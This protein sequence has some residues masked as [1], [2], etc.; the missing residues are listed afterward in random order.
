MNNSALQWGYLDLATAHVADACM[1]LGVPVRCAPKHLRPLWDGIHLVGRVHPVIHRGSVDVFL[2]ALD[3]SERGEVLVV[4]NGGR[5]D[6]A[7]IGD[8]VALE[9]AQAGL[10]GIV[11]WGL[12]RDTRQLTTIRMPIFSAGALAVGPDRAD[13]GGPDMAVSEASCGSHVVTAADFVLAD[14]DGVLFVPIDRAAEVAVQA[15]SIRDTERTQAARM[16]AGST[17]RE[18]SQFEAYRAARQ[19]DPRVTF[20]THLRSIG[21]AVEE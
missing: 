12:H 10:S 13:E 16:T 2:D 1:R 14:D 11:V 9:T 19:A 6:E 20:R 5:D 8:L 18:Q 15:A 17:F 7:C 4:D 3:R 21:A